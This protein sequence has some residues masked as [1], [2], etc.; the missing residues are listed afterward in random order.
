[1]ALFLWAIVSLQA[2]PMVVFTIGF[3]YTFIA[4]F[5]FHYLLNKRRNQKND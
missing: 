3:S 4:Y 2:V 1:M 5:L